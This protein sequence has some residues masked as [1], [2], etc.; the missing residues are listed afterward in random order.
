MTVFQCESF[1]ISNFESSVMYY[2]ALR[3]TRTI[4]Y[5]ESLGFVFN[6]SGSKFKCLILDSAEDISLI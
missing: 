3:E 4:F 6:P 2:S 5:T 1:K